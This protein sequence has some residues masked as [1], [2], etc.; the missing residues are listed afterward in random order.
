MKSDGLV[1]RRAEIEANIQTMY[2]YGAG[3]AEERAFHRGRIKNGKNFVARRTSEGWQFA[4]S[5]F[6]GYA[7]NDTSHM[8]KL[9]DRDGG[10]TNIRI[11]EILGEPLA[12]GDRGYEDVDQAYRDY[13]REHGFKPSRHAQGRKYWML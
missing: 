3:S 1:S 6:A 10:V 13:V 5:K 2:A 12:A 11:T 4:P 8:D 7:R 9:N